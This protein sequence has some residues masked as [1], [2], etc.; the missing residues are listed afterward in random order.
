MGK[1]TQNHP[2]MWSSVSPNKDGKRSSFVLELGPEITGPTR[3]HHIDNENDEHRYLLTAKMT[4][5]D[6][7]DIHNIMKLSVIHKDNSVDRFEIPGLNKIDLDG[8]FAGKLDFLSNNPNSQ[9]SRV[10]LEENQDGTYAMTT[11]P[12]QPP[13][14]PQPQS[15]SN[16][17]V[18]AHIITVAGLGALGYAGA[19]YFKNISNNRPDTK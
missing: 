6:S 1:K 10:E 7:G 8:K 9:F 16:F 11:T 19:M 5:L 12:N 17:G 2:K 4:K 15:Q 14:K 18:G 3:S 13:S